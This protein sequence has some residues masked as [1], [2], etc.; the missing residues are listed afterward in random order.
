MRVAIIIALC[1]LLLA[2]CNTR[3]KELEKQNAEL[4]TK[5]NELYKELTNRDEYISQVMES[6]NGMQ[7]NIEGTREK[8]KLIL[9]ETDKM[10]GGKKASS[11]EVRQQVLDQLAQIDSTLRANRRKLDSLVTRV[12]SQ[13]KQ[14]A[15]LNKMIENL[16]TTLAEREQAIATL[17][18]RV[19]VLE[20]E[21]SAKTA[22]V[23]ERDATINEQQS[24][25]SRQTTKINTGYYIAGSR[26][27]LK[28]KGIIADEGGLLWGLFGTTTI[29]A[30]GF[31]NTLFTPI[32]KTTEMRIEVK[33][34]V[35]EIV[36]RRN[37]TIYSIVP[38]ADKEHTTIQILKADQFWQDNYLV[39]ITN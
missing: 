22:M 5:S 35:S 23:A 26:G 10:E 4:Q 9:S 6:I 20:G 19:A 32:N 27:D 13:R 39:I 18:E 31:D 2:G 12:R 28:Q 30:N 3:E 11:G 34:S 38:S 25:I 16:K 8:E 7:E 24:I 36:P 14:I 21:V 29:L 37:P 15:S 1:A 33:G 17:Q